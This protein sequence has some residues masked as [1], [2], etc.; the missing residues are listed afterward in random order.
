MCKCHRFKVQTVLIVV[1]A[2][3]SSFGITSS[4]LLNQKL[5]S[6]ISIEKRIETE[7][8][9][10]S[11]KEI[12]DVVDLILSRNTVKDTLEAELLALV[13]LYG[14]TKVKFQAPPKFIAFLL[15]I[16]SGFRYEAVSPKGAV[17]IAQVRPKYWKG[18]KEIASSESEFNNPI[19]NVALAIHI[20]N[21]YYDL[22][23]NPHKAIDMYSGNA[24]PHSKLK[25][26][27]KKGG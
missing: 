17:G 21:H 11:K 2:L 16:E 22:C 25:S 13:A 1:L 3:I 26:M 7:N 12:S 23:G 10:I 15:D 8:F 19:K 14:S 27:L 18:F 24:R 20:L 6:Y 9:V 5:K 4:V